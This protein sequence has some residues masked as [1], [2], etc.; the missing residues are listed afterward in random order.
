MKLKI[1]TIVDMKKSIFNKK[2]KKDVI[3]Q[4]IEVHKLS[5]RQADIAYSIIKGERLK[6]IAKIKRISYICVQKHIENIIKKNPGLTKNTFYM[7]L[8]PKYL[9]LTNEG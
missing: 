7:L 3:S 8:A 9:D 6:N 4:M 2:L 1:S 5:K